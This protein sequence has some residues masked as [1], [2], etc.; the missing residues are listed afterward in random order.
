MNDHGFAWLL[1]AIIVFLVGLP[2]AEELHVI[3]TT[4]VRASLYTCLL[5]IGVWSLRGAGRMFGIGITFAVVGI[6]LNFIHVAGDGGTLFAWSF[7][8]LLGFLAT[9]IWHT[10]KIISR[11]DESNFDRLIGAVCLYLLLGLAWAIVY[12]LFHW[13]E[14][15][16]FAGLPVDASIQFDSSFVF[17]SFV[18]MTT[19]GYGD[20]VP[21]TP[22]L[23]TFAYLQA[24][25]GQFYLAILVASLVSAYIASANRNTD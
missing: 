22:T 14:P 7:V 13:A 18:T 9:A 23:R 3:N 21:L 17:F 8:A 25:V 5:V 6:L 1:L 16:S 2:V 4:I 15:E 10:L 11:A 20:I 12:S 19:L 24:I